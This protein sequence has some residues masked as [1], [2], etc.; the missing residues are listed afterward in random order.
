MSCPTY[1]RYCQWGFWLWGKWPW[2]TQYW[3]P[4][5]AS[6][7][8]IQFSLTWKPSDPRSHTTHVLCQLR[9]KETLR[10]VGR[11][12]SLADASMPKRREIRAG[13]G[14]IIELP[15]VVDESITC[16]NGEI[17][18]DLARSR[19]NG[20]AR[21]YY[22]WLN[23]CGNILNLRSHTVVECTSFP[24]YE[25]LDSSIDFTDVAIFEC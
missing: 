13:K 9:R 19:R 20:L 16:H 15:A 23:Q 2:S 5:K 10:C 8:V 11:D 18:E 24:A 4:L 1:I 14:P 6:R 3:W 7:S 12:V 21:V 25:R 22:H 17:I